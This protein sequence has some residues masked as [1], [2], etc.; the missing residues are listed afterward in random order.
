ML[1]KEEAKCFHYY[2]GDVK[3]CNVII[4]QFTMNVL[5]YEFPDVLSMQVGHHLCVVKHQAKRTAMLD[6]KFNSRI[7]NSLKLGKR[8][9]Q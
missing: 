1:S 7:Y 6:M 9:Y 5:N 3:S 8:G 4:P 2:S